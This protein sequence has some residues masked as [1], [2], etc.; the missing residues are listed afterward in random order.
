MKKGLIVIIMVIF[1]LT[2]AACSNEEPITN[3]E[4]DLAQMDAA[5]IVNYFEQAGLPVANIIVYAE[6][7]DVY[8]ALERADAFT[9]KVLFADSRLDQ[10][11][12]KAPI[13]GSV[14][15]YATAELAAARADYIE[16]IFDIIPA[17]GEYIYLQDNVL[18]RVDRALLAEEATAYLAVLQGLADG[19]IINLNTVNNSD[20]TA[21]AE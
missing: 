17:A 8:G 13:G 19:E 12:A 1:V 9:S 5:V 14:E 4:I 16:L 21:P 18:L 6:D 20:D 15:V 7:T 11:G 3:P 10:S 2:L